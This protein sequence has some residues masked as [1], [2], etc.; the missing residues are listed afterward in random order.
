MRAK[1]IRE[2]FKKGAKPVGISTEEGVDYLIKKWQKTGLKFGWQFFDGDEREKKREFFSKYYPLIEK[3]LNKI[4]EAG[5]P[6][7]HITFWG[8]HLEVK[9]YQLIKGNWALFHC[10]T[11]KDA[12]LVKKVIE[13]MTTGGGAINIREDSD[14]IQLGETIMRESDP[15]HNEWI[16][17]HE[18]NTGEKRKT[19]LDFLDGI[20][21][22]RR[23]LKGIL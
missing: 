10:I 1:L 8:D 19:D 21:E 4:H 3:Y 11:K 13:N 18:K 14:H 15:E 12:E 20:E 23:K 16:K 22:I 7:E 2:E 6:W 5:V 17:K 9:T